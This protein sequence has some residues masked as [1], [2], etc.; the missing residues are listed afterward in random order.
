MSTP[1]FMNSDPDRRQAF[2]NDEFS[3]TSS[4]AYMVRISSVKSITSNIENVPFKGIA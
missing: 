3:G 2:V 4:Y 1:L